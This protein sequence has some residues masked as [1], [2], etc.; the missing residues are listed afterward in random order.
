MAL[1]KKVLVAEDNIISQHL[2]KK[3]L[4]VLRYDV[5]I[6]SNGREALDY[7]QKNFAQIGLILMDGDMP[8]LNGHEAAKAIKQW[9][10]D[11]K[12]VDVVPIVAWTAHSGIGLNR[13]SWNAVGV[14]DFLSKPFVIDEFKNLLLKYFPDAQFS[15]PKETLKKIA[16]QAESKASLILDASALEQLLMLDKKNVGLFQNLITH[17][18]TEG[19][20][21]LAEIALH[22]KDKQ[23]EPLRKAAHTL[24]SSSASFGATDL[25]QL[26]KE[27]EYHSDDFPAITVWLDKAIKLFEQ[28]LE[29]LEKVVP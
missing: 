7:Y 21:L 19:R 12:L 28:S 14:L 5:F 9:E 23:A 15:S 6:A 27:M 3:M 1:G 26:C 8:V 25:A 13:E 4:A 11:N 17:Y 22:L 10:V 2:I 16:V 29:A 20:R 18:Q 24:K